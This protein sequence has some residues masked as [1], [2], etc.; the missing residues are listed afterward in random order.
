[1]PENS[2]H[3]YGKTACLGNSLRTQQQHG[4]YTDVLIQTDENNVFPCHRG[5]LAADSE[6]WSAM[7]NGGF[8]EEKKKVIELENINSLAFQQVL[9]YVYTGRFTISSDTV[10]NIYKAADFLQYYYVTQCC[11]DFIQEDLNIDTYIDYLNFSQLFSLEILIAAV[12]N[13]VLKNFDIVTK[14]NS[15]GQLPLEMLMEILRSNDLDCCS[16]KSVVDCIVNYLRTSNE[17][18]SKEKMGKLVTSLRYGLLHTDDLESLNGLSSYIGNETAMKMQTD[19]VRYERYEYLRPFIS[20]KS[21]APRCPPHVVILGGVFATFLDNGRQYTLYDECIALNMMKDC[22][23]KDNFNM[24]LPKALFGFEAVCVGNFIFIFGGILAS[25]LAQNSVY[26][27]DMSKQ[28]W[29]NLANMPLELFFH[30]CSLLNKNV[31]VVGG[32]NANKES[33]NAVLAYDIIRNSWEEKSPFPKHVHLAAA[34]TV[35]NKF[36]VSGGKHNKQ[37]MYDRIWHYE[38]DGDVWVSTGVMTSPRSCHS[39]NHHNGKL[40]IAGGDISHNTDTRDFLCFDLKTSQC[41]QLTPMIHKRSYAAT[42]VYNDKLFVIGGHGKSKDDTSINS[43]ATDTIQVY[44]F[45]KCTWQELDNITMPYKTDQLRCIL[46]F[47]EA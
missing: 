4:L 44:D 37:I 11:I 16:E 40:Y 14:H 46:A 36:Y 39:M 35:E 22:D 13:F 41:S 34:C 19:I 29:L 27:F 33:S 32:L 26:R 31:F 43:H 1:M 38:S 25:K 24:K 47:N 23:R 7:F 2:Y 8:S 6:F 28:T 5:V 42:V 18:L 12:K 21:F 30:A 20:P 15:L 17:E 45:K 3:H 10:I 9:S